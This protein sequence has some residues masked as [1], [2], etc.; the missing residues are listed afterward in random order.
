MRNPTPASNA[1][2]VPPMAPMATR[3]Q[4]MAV[5]SF[6]R[7]SPSRIVTTRRGSPTLRAIDVAAT[8][9]G[10]ATTAPRARATGKVTGRSHQVTTPTPSA[11]ISTSST[12]RY[13]IGRRLCR[14]SMI[15]VRIAAE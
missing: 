4:V 13:A 10:G 6:T 12:D 3:R 11:V 9:S 5:A 2:N 15:E 8:A 7:D 1:E 14:K